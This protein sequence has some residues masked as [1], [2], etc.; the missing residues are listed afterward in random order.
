VVAAQTSSL[1]NQLEQF[2]KNRLT[3]TTS[4]PLISLPD[5]RPTISPDSHVIQLFILITLLAIFAYFLWRKI[6]ARRHAHETQ[7]VL[8]LSNRNEQVKIP[9]LTLNHS[10]ELYTFSASEFVTHLS[11]QRQLI[12]AT[13]FISWNSFRIKH[14]FLSRVYELPT[15]V[16]LDI[17]T[18]CR[19]QRILNS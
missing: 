9:L 19:A 1:E 2:R 7:L 4:R 13:M 8:E 11:I 10:V 5:Y 3:T 6:W 15:T 12:K 14:R 18:V 16:T 17:L